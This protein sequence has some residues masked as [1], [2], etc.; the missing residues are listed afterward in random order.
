MKDVIFLAEGINGCS[1]SQGLPVWKM[2]GELFS[3]IEVS[4]TPGS[5]LQRRNYGLDRWKIADGLRE[6]QP[7]NRAYEIDT[8]AYLYT[9]NVRTHANARD[10]CSRIVEYDHDISLSLPRSLS[11]V[12]RGF[13]EPKRV[14]T[15]PKYRD[16]C[17]SLLKIDSSLCAAQCIS[18]VHFSARKNPRDAANRK[19]EGLS[20][21][22]RHF[23]EK[24]QL[25]NGLQ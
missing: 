24:D 14:G 13:S 25:R 17:R 9:C 21:R 15:C 8:Q 6:G 12:S 16:T 1:W 22:V 3:V 4:V 19:R 18:Y 2:T 23:L 11:N 20:L 7:R 5:L 10:A